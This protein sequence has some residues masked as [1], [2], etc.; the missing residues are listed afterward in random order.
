MKAGDTKDPKLTTLIT[1]T[2]HANNDT[3]QSNFRL[4][5]V[6]FLLIVMTIVA[7]LHSWSVSST[8]S[9]SKKQ[10]DIVEATHVVTPSSNFEEQKRTTTVIPTVT[11]LQFEKQRRTND[12]DIDDVHDNDSDA[13]R[14]FDN[15]PD[16]D[17][18]GVAHKEGDIDI[19]SNGV[20]Q[21]GPNN[22]GEESRIDNV[23][24]APLSGLA[25]LH[26]QT[27]D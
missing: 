17:S 7:S 26:C 3:N 25:Q 14:D 18:D 2:S 21:G 20:R 10:K 8:S 9:Y 22:G 15:G 19:Y 12:N 6:G 13:D 5:L 27:G 4:T 23:A 11:E 24:L 16:A 1:N